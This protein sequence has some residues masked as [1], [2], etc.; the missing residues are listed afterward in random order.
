MT[1]TPSRSVRPEDDILYQ[2]RVRRRLEQARQP[3]QG[4]GWNL[5]ESQ[6]FTSEQIR[7]SLRPK[8]AILYR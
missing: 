5:A 8:D 6:G 3:P 1:E 2:W 4:Q 7:V